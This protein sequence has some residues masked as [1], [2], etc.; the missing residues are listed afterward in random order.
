M[1]DLMEELFHYNVSGND[2]A[3]GVVS[4]NFSGN[5]QIPDDELNMLDR[6]SDVMDVIVTPASGRFTASAAFFTRLRKT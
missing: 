5:A 1:T 2:T 6:V 4:Y 3:L